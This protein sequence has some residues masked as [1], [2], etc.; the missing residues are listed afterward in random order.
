[1]TGNDLRHFVFYEKRKDGLY[2]WRFAADGRKPG[3]DKQIVGHSQ[4]LAS[5]FTFKPSSWGKVTLGLN[6]MER[7]RLKDIREALALKLQHAG[8]L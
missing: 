5:G 2:E 4:R 3:I 8:L 6:D 7:P 1:M